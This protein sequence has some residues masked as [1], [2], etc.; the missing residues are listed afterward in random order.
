VPELD[1]DGPDTAGA[2]EPVAVGSPEFDSDMEATAGPIPG[3]H[4][5]HSDK[6]GRT[7]DVVVERV[8]DSVVERI[9]ATDSDKLQAKFEIDTGQGQRI[10]VRLTID[11]NIVSAR[12]DAP[13]EQ[14]RDLLAGHA[15]ELTQRLESEGFIPSD[16]QFCLAGD[17]QQT[18]DHEVRPGHAKAVPERAPEED[19]EHLTIVEPEAYMFESWA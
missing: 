8:F 17:R 16:I 5:S 18:P 4:I 11:G 2:P 6:S 19:M 14:A 9:Q 7:F 3:V 15:W 1:L 12:I 10:R 13:D